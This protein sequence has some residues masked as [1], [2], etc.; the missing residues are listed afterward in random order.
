L[1]LNLC[2]FAQDDLQATAAKSG[3][4]VG[5]V[6]EHKARLVV[7]LGEAFGNICRGWLAQHTSLGMDHA[8]ATHVKQN[9]LVLRMP[10]AVFETDVELVAAG[11]G[12]EGQSPTLIRC[13][14]YTLPRDLRGF[15]I[16][17]QIGE[18]PTQ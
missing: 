10:V 1:R 16:L 4:G 8:A 6:G 7:V 14:R 3:A 17:P 13:K 5:A 12:L 9:V 11:T 2:V 15:L 18:H